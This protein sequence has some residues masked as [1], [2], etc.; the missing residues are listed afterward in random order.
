MTNIRELLLS[1][2][3]SGHMPAQQTLR[4]KDGVTVLAYI[5]KLEQELYALKMN[6]LD[7]K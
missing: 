1:T 6:R 4:N 3:R 2:E 5:E 7:E